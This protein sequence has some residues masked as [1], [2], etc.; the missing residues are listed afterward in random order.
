MQDVDA[1]TRS[2]MTE[3]TDAINSA[4]PRLR[5]RLRAQ[6]RLATWRVLSG[7]LPRAVDPVVFR[8]PLHRHHDDAF[9]ADAICQVLARPFQPEGARLNALARCRSHGPVLVAR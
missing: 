5:H 6:A 8:Q 7:V 3:R 1:G 9:W 2:G 4:K